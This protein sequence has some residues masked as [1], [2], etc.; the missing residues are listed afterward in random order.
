MLKRHVQNHPSLSGLASVLLLELR[1]EAEAVRAGVCSVVCTILTSRIALGMWLNCV[2][3]VGI[4][5]TCVM[6]Y[7]FTVC[8]STRTVDIVCSCIATLLPVSCCVL[9]WGTVM[10]ESH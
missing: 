5:A 6:F 1:L 2:C 4:G 7:V 10:P 3:F 8:V 9:W